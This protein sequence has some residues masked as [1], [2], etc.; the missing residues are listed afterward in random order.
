MQSRE[1]QITM[2]KLTNAGGQT[3]RANERSFVYRPPAWR[4]WRNVK[5][6]YIG[7]NSIR[8]STLGARGFSCAVSGFGQVLKSGFAAR[9]FG[10]RPNTCRPP[11]DETK[12]PDARE[13][14]P[15]VPR[16]G[17]HAFPTWKLF[18][19]FAVSV[20]KMFLSLIPDIKAYCYR[21][22]NLVQ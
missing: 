17:K 12:L 2:V 11:A 8:R 22:Q 15:L 19:K 6:T 1:T 4:R 3:K 13:K 14:K 9:V 10:V 7:D 16:V 21:E 18:I 20:F 5:T